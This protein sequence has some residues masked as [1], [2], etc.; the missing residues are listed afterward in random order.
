MRKLTAILF[1]FLSASTT[2][3]GQVLKLPWLVSHFIDH[4]KEGQGINAFMHEHYVHH[5]GDNDDQ[6]EDDQLPFKT[7]TIQQTSFTCLLPVIESVNDTAA[8]VVKAK[9]LLPAVAISSDYLKD[10]FHPPRMVSA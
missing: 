9:T 1:L 4:H 7:T 10:I 8:P 6:E 2:E 5:H 3:F